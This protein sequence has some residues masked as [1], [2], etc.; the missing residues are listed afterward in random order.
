[1]VSNKTNN[2]YLAKINQITYENLKRTND[3]IQEYLA[4]T[5]INLI[6]DIYSSYDTCL[7]YTS[8]AADD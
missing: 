7:L 2:I 8:D 3:N 5:N 1:M 6:D 4:K